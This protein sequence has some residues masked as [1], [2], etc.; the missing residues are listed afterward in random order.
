MK[1][2]LMSFHLILIV[3]GLMAQESAP[4][5][6]YIVE[7]YIDPSGKE[8]EKIIVPGK[9]PEHFRMPPASPSESTYSLAN[10]P[11][12]D[13]CFGCSATSASMI[14][15]YYDR[16][17]LPNCYTG[18]TNGG[19]SPMNNSAWGTVVINSETRSQCP[20]SAT[21][22]GLDGRA[23]RGHVDDYW[24]QTNN[25]GPDPFIVNGW[26]EHTY[27]ECTG[28][29]M[30]TNQSD[31]GNVD[32]GTVF[33]NYLD[34]S[35]YNGPGADNDDGMNGF[36][37]FFESRGYYVESH[38]NQ[39][40]YGYNG[41]TIGFTF[42]QYKAEI[43][44]GRPVLIQIAGH[45]MVGMGYNDTGTKIYLHDTWDYSTHE[46]TWGGSYAG[47][48]HYGVGV[49]RV[50]ANPTGPCAS[51]YTIGG[52]GAGNSQSYPGGGTGVW[53]NSSA[54][55][56]NY[57]S[58][59]IER[60]YSF[61]APFTGTYNLQVTSASGWVIYMWKEA[62][63]SPYDWNCLQAIASPGS[64]GSFSWT[65]GHTYSI[66]LDDYDN[67]AGTH[68]FYINGVENV[69]ATQTLQN[70]TIAN[71]QSE[72]YDA[73][74]T[75]TTAGSNTTFIVQSGGDATLIAGQNILMLPGT[76][77][78]SGS[79]VMAKI[80]TIGAYCSSEPPAVPMMIPAPDAGQRSKVE[81]QNIK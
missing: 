72:C 10:V 22:Q 3:I 4:V 67:T 66:L 8:V 33:Y 18:P 48:Q 24:I 53:F 61:V 31:Y 28:D 81:G 58:P 20:F 16:T 38:F 62:S 52:V 68:T 55:A 14:A 59:G 6:D 76:S 74:Q 37:L 50:V 64:Y 51:V 27:G 11:A 80:T 54:N 65:A 44:A 30:K 75:I 29:Y 41:N 43:D 35:P 45:T 77:L 17:T 49:I 47:M 21:R 73:S 5:S 13:W 60:I 70:I 56:C 39:Y 46:M 1:K 63:C 71:G 69:P 40:I 57:D 42:T 32:G 36:R 12:F 34:G 78:Q 2:L 23:T 26:T 7:R 79:S 15:G 25:A 9:P 19:V